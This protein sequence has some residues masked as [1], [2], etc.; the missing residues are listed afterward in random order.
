MSSYNTIREQA[1]EYNRR[2]QELK[3]AIYTFGN[4]SAFDPDKGV[5][6]IKPSG[7]P[8]NELTPESMVVSERCC[9]W[10]YRCYCQ[11]YC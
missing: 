8:Y 4:V 9:F 7:V 11:R 3:L 5:L 1:F 10:M 6:S 2:I